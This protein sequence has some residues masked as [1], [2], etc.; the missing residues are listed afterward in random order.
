MTRTDHFADFLLLRGV[1][2]GDECSR[3]N[4]FGTRL[5][6]TT[7]TW[8]SGSGG[9]TM[10]NDVCDKCWG[11]GRTSVKWPSHRSAPA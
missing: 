1:D 9:M 10:T 5:Y 6:E 7:G 3:C 11:S 4:G 2:S 8:R